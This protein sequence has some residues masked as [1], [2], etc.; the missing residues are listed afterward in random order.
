[1]LVER[2]DWVLLGS[3]DEGK[4]VKEGSVG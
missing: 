1:M 3:A 2:S 4:P